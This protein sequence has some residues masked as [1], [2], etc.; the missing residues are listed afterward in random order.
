M[1]FNLAW[2][3]HE[4]RSGDVRLI[5]GDTVKVARFVRQ[6]RGFSHD[7]LL[8]MVDDQ[9]KILR[10][11]VPIH[12]ALQDSGRIEVST[13]PAFH[14]ILPL[15]IDTDSAYVDRPGT[16]RPMRFAHPE[17]AATHVF[18]PEWRRWRYSRTC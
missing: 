14:P 11:V 12:R 6:Q 16:S 1:W 5:T 9:Y 8:A 13:T 10:A 18:C 7:D 17:D 15:L 3:G 4:F 2:F